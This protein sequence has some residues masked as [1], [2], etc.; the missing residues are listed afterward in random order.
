MKGMDSIRSEVYITF[1]LKRLLR[2]IICELKEDRI[3][4]KGEKFNES[5][6]SQFFTNS[7]STL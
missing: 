1:V 5:H 3:Q 7:S 6:L 2:R 4:S